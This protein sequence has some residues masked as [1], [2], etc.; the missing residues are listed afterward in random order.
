MNEVNAFEKNWD[1]FILKY[2]GKL[3]SQAKVRK[4]T[5]DVAR[6]VLLETLSSWGSEYEESGRWLKIY[7]DRYP[8]SGDKICRMLESITLS[9][10]LP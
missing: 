4:I 8:H 9:E 2:K 6:N 10:A 3:L 7:C 5:Y 1:K